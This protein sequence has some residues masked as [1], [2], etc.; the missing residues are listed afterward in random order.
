MYK[1]V[2]VPVDGST[3]SECILGHVKEIAAGCKVPE[4]VLL[5]VMEPMR[6][7]VYEI[8]QDFIDRIQDAGTEQTREYLTGLAD[9]LNKEGIITSIAVMQGD[10]AESIL[11]YANNNGVDLIMISTHGKSGITRW[12]VGSVAD[13]VIRLSPVPVL[14]VSPP[15]CRVSA[16]SS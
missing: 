13:K 9:D 12:A 14:S 11:D 4:V 8:P 10:A 16:V 15:G 7:V 5:S 6:S 2:L 1:K 3:N